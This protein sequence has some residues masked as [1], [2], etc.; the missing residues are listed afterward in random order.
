MGGWGGGTYSVMDVGGVRA[1]RVGKSTWRWGRGEEWRQ[2][3]TA[4]EE[5]I[6]LPWKS[7]CGRPVMNGVE[8]AIRP[9]CWDDG[10]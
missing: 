8:D 3:P 2:S 1:W 10:T 5:W 6:E 9:T 4:P 7:V